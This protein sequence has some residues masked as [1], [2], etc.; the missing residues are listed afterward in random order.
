MK[1]KKSHIIP[2]ILFS[3]LLLVE[4]VLAEDNVTSDNHPMGYFI[5]Q[6]Q[7]QSQQASDETSNS[8][9]DETPN[10]RARSFAAA[11]VASAPSNLSSTDTSLPRQDAVDISDYQKWMV[12]SDFNALKSEGVKTAI[13]KLTEGTSYLNPSAAKQILMAKNAGLTVATYH[14]VYDPTNIQNEAAF[15]AQKAKALGLSTNTVMIEDAESP[16]QYYNWTAV[17]QVFK[18]TMNKAG[19]N[20][21]RYYTSQ[22]WVSSGVMNA[23][24]LGAKNLWVAQYLYGKPSN[25]NLKNT[26]YGAWQYTSQMYFQSTPNLSSHNLDTSIDYSDFFSN[27]TSLPRISVNFANLPIKNPTVSPFKDINNSL[28][29]K[30]INWIYSVGITT[31]KSPILY[32]PLAEVSRGEMATFLYRLAGSPSYTPP[33]NIYTDINQYKNQ[34]LWLSAANV[35]NGTAPLYSPNSS[36]T[37]GQM[38]AFL[39]RMAKAMSKTPSSGTYTSSFK[40]IQNNQF[41]NDINWLKITGITTGYSPTSYKPNETVKR[42]EMAAF[43]HRFYN[44]FK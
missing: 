22:G 2:L 44:K 5:K 6:E 32:D 36:V 8:S 28:L 18:S 29:K 43:I 24:T 26:D 19:F 12:Q 30:D 4:P 42:E 1:L 21:I 15:Y 10:I 35:T 41:K 9:T 27:P 16:S 20:N 13:I 31:G 40:D 34:I 37:R 39:H 17:S 33:Y 7:E 23:S 11:P 14:F 25:Q 38:A 3:G